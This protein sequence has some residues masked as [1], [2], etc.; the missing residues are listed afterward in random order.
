MFPKRS[1]WSAQRILLELWRKIVGDPDN[2]HFLNGIYHGVHDCE[3]VMMM[4]SDTIELGRLLP[5]MELEFDYQGGLDKF[6][7]PN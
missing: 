3:F 7:P 2:R 6:D 4:L 1:R 5:P